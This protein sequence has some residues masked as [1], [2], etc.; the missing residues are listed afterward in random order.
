MTPQEAA[1]ARSQPHAQVPNPQAPDTQQTPETASAPVHE[2]HPAW[3]ILK[4]HAAALGHAALALAGIAVVGGAVAVVGIGGG[5]VIQSGLNVI[6]PV[7]H[8]LG[9]TRVA[10]G[11]AAVIGGIAMGC[12]NQWRKD[13]PKATPPT[14]EPKT[15]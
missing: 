1:A 2:V 9:N 3:E 11:V 7:L 14:T 5:D 10:I 12:F 4:D 6:H 8:N 13:H 15:K